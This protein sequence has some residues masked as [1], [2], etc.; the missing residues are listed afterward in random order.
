MCCETTTRNIMYLFWHILVYT[1]NIFWRYLLRLSPAKCH[2]FYNETLHVFMY[3]QSK[4]WDVHCAPRFMVRYGAFWGILSSGIFTHVSLVFCT[5]GTTIGAVMGKIQLN[6]SY[7]S[8]RS[9]WCNSNKAKLIYGIYIFIVTASLHYI[10]QMVQ[11]ILLF[12]AV[13][14]HP[15]NIH[16]VLFCFA[17][18]WLYLCPQWV[19]CLSKL[20][21]VVSLSLRQLHDSLSTIHFQRV[22]LNH[23]A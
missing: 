19:T 23:L 2:C 14:V 1:Q 12:L 11:V 8:I 21:I 9:W 7:E 6:N 16:T 20:F 15:I 4:W 3:R 5:A 13:A 10:M 22:Q 17:S 18:L